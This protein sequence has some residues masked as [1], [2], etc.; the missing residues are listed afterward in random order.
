MESDMAQNTNK[1]SNGAM[2]KISTQWQADWMTKV[3]GN[4]YNSS[5]K[6]IFLRIA[7]FGEAGCW[8]NN[9]TFEEEFGRSEATIRRSI[10]ALWSKGD[11]I[12]TGWNGH[13]RKMYA[14][15]HPRVRQALN[16][17]YNKALRS[18]KVTS[19]EEY[20][21]KTRLRMKTLIPD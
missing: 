19:V 12:V 15:S 5:A 4:G 11:I 18:G 17:L 20:R 6:L 2:R 21:K 7:S 1:R 14:A 8:M 9:E 10:T 3:L 16:A 13:G